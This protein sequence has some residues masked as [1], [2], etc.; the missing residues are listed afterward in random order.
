M[1]HKYVCALV[2]ICIIALR[3]L[4]LVSYSYHN[5]GISKNSDKAA[6]YIAE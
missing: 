6:E 2:L 3:V 5:S 4:F 1:Y